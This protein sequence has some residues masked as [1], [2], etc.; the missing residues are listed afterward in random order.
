MKKY[1]MSILIFISFNAFSQVDYGYGDYVNQ[2]VIKA[3]NGDGSA[4]N[5]LG[6]M[7]KNGVGKVPK[8]LIQAR[9]WFELSV[10]NRWNLG[11]YNM[12]VFYENGLGDV[13][14]DLNKAIEYYKIAA[15]TGHVP[16]IKKLESLGIIK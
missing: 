10:K 2:L 8:D 3:N 14:Q 9:K 16:S 7:Y 4:A 5:H 1:F 6:N 15:E 13:P 11:Y 12:G